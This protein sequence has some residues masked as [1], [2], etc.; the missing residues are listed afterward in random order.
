VPHPKAEKD[1]EEEQEK[2]L[3]FVALTRAKQD[4]FFA[5]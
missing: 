5:R 3:Y 2:N 1:W 4:L